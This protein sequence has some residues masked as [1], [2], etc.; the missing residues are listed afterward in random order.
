MNE[1]EQ[2]I[3]KSLLEKCMSSAA[4]VRYYH[5]FLKAVKLRQEIERAAANTPTKSNA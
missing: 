1:D 2:R 3:A 5:E 4:N